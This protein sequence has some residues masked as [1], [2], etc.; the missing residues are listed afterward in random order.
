VQDYERIRSSLNSLNEKMAQ[1]G[2][3]AILVPDGLPTSDLGEIIRLRIDSLR[4]Q[5]KI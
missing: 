3:E 2:A 1:L 5:A 4:S